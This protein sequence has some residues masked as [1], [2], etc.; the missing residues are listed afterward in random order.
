MRLVGAG[1]QTARCEPASTL[2]LSLL[3]RGHQLTT[4]NESNSRVVHLLPFMTERMFAPSQPTCQPA[5]QPASQP[6]TQPPNH[7]TT[8]RPTQPPNQPTTRPTNKPHHQPTNQPTNQ[9]EAP[10]GRYLEKQ[11]PLKEPLPLPERS[12]EYR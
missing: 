7:P 3:L 2:M 12:M 5:R 4:A 6:A 1:K 10:V 8:Q 11:F 9:Q